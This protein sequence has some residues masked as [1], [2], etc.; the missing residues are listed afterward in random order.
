MFH[1]PAAVARTSKI[2]CQTLRKFAI[3]IS[4]MSFDSSDSQ[5]RYRNQFFKTTLC[6]YYLENTCRKGHL[7]SHAHSADE[8]QNKPVLSKTRMCKAILRTGNCLDSNCTFAHEIDELVA[9]NAFFRTKLCDFHTN[10]F[11]K[12]GD[13]CRYAHSSSELGGDKPNT[14]KD[15]LVCPPVDY[16]D[17]PDTG[18]PL[19]RKG[20]FS[21]ESTMA[22][23]CGSFSSLSDSVPVL[24]PL[25][26][27]Y[28]PEKTSLHAQAAMHDHYSERYSD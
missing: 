4:V 5:Y 3:A 27:L 14:K 8:L 11:C 16:N 24:N 1:E 7:C 12:L 21:S 13:K 19:R 23:S 15:A 10:G 9:A 20:A 6:K 2:H 25:V 26:I 28:H 17:S 18:Y 22:N